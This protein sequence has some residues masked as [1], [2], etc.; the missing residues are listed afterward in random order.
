M[1]KA[2]FASSAVLAVANSAALEPRAKQPA[3]AGGI[4]QFLTNYNV[5]N[6]EAEK[7]CGS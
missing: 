6:P 2:I 7:I 5:G 1:L 4:Q 3:P